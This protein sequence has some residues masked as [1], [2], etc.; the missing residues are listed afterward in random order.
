[1]AAIEAV[2]A[3]VNPTVVQGD[4]LNQSLARAIDS[5][6]SIKDKTTAVHRVFYS[7]LA[8]TLN[9]IREKSKGNEIDFD[10]KNLKS[11]LFGFPIEIEALRMIRADTILAISKTS[12]L[13]MESIK[14]EVVA[15]RDAEHS[16]GVRERLATACG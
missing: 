11:L 7:S 10:L 14:G 2:F 15:L 9:R 12:S 1:M 6:A 8:K 4:S 5:V 13:L 16:K 3:S